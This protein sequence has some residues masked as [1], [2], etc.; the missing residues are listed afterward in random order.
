MTSTLKIGII[1]LDTSHA[2]AFTKLLNDANHAHHVAGGQVVAAFPGGSPDFHLSIS[3]VEG[4]TNELRDNWGVTMLD[5]PEAVAQ[6]CDGVLLCSVDGRVHWEQFSRI[7]AFGKPVFIDKPL[8]VNAAD[9]QKIADL[10]RQSGVPLLSCSSLRYAQ[11]LVDALENADRAAILGADCFGPMALEATQPGLFWY[12]I[13]SVEMLYA[14]LGPGCERVA[15]TSNDD[16][17]LVTGVWRDGR[18]GT[19]RGNRK[20]NNSFGA[21]WHGAAKSQ[22]I[23]AGAHPKPAYAGLLERLMS[24]FNSGQ[25]PLDVAETLEIVRFIEAANQSRLDGQSVVL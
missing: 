20:G 21:L 9:A 12:G 3:R 23:D 22:F 11:P 16:F 4:F 10:A 5:T 15:A 1:G 17:D 19:V 25:A 14:M 7:A 2:V 24:M 13:H 8:A 6:G 18:I